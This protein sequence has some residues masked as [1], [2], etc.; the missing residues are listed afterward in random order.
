MAFIDDNTSTTKNKLNISI[1]EKDDID[2][3]NDEEV[4]Q[5][6]TAFLQEMQKNSEANDF[7]NQMNLLME[8]G[9]NN[10]MNDNMFLGDT[11]KE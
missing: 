10:S 3:L 2:D 4:E 8:S 7:L 1:N 11:S 6:F 5:E 9:M